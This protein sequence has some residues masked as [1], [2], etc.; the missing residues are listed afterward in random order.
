MW[1]DFAF[2]LKP[3]ANCICAS[4][5]ARH[6]GGTILER[7]PIELKQVPTGSPAC[8]QKSR[9]PG[10]LKRTRPPARFHSTH[11]Q[12]QITRTLRNRRHGGQGFG[13]GGTAGVA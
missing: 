7:V 3:T 2:T 10:R 11:V 13:G 12:T 1:P 9:R 5:A 4:L 6:P 8:A